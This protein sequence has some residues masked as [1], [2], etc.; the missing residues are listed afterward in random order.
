MNS[1]IALLLLIV[2]LFS[3]AVDRNIAELNSIDLNELEA[4]FMLPP[5]HHIKIGNGDEPGKPLW[6]GIELI[7]KS[8]Q[9]VIP[10]Q[11]IHIYHT[12]DTGEYHPSNLS[13]ETTARLN[14][15]AITNKQGRIF[16]RTILPGDYGSSSDNRHIHTTVIGAHPEA[17]DIHFKQ[18]TG[19]MG[20]N[21][22]NSSDQHFLADLKQNQDSVLVSF[23]KMEIKKPVLVKETDRTQRP[24]CEWCGADEAPNDISWEA[25]LATEDEPG[26]RLILEGT[27]FQKDGV[28]PAKNVIVYAYQTNAKGLYEKKGDETGNGLRH[29]HIRAWV[30]TDE[31]G[32]YK[33]YT[34]KP[35]PYPNLGEP[36]HVHMTLK[37]DDFDEYWISSTWFEG[38]EIITEDMMKNRTRIGGFSNVVPLQKDE[39]GNWIAHRDIIINPPQ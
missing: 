20:S 8:T 36:A 15:E 7:D 11:R 17:Y 23:V 29:G 5:A 38:D 4:Y 13:D 2:G 6:L 12:D 34:I 16:V 39:N 22:I 27:I 33:F 9:Q 3:C 32:R 25:Q 26:E 1:K 28:S 14:G 21:F 10:N 24:S 19:K 35:A 18:F 31:Q 30:K 37:G